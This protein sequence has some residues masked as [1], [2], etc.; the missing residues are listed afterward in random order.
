MCI[1][2]LINIIYYSLISKNTYYIFYSIYILIYFT[3]ILL[4]LFVLCFITV[5]KLLYQ[6]VTFVEVYSDNGVENTQANYISSY[7]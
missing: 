2:I 6:N 5:K 1:N 3:V 4:E 7:I